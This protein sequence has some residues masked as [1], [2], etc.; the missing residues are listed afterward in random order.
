[1]SEVLPGVRYTKNHEYVRVDGKLA[2]IG[3]TDHA[4]HELTEI[5]FVDLPT[6]GKEIGAGDVVANVESVK[7]VSEV[8]APVSGVVRE[9]NDKLVDS[10][11]LLNTD[12]Y[13]EGWIAVIEMADVSG[14]AS[15]MSAE[16]Y[17]KLLGE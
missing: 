8:L 7:T 15:L 16:D 6:I 17:R 11:E 4:Q 13:G 9:V 10:P 2:R 3:L 14:L 1:M 12:P 5:V